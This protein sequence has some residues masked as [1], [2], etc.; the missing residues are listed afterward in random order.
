MHKPSHYSTYRNFCQYVGIDT[1][2][3]LDQVFNNIGGL[4]LGQV[5]TAMMTF[6]FRQGNIGNQVSDNNLS[7]FPGNTYGLGDYTPGLQPNFNQGQF[8]TPYFQTSLQ[9]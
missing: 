7:L 3:N 4:T 6:Q 5:N 1:V 9:D 2:A 8:P